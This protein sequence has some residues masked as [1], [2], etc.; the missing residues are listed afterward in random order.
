MPRSTTTFAMGAIVALV[1]G[2]GTAYAAN[3]G[4]LKIGWSNNATQTTTLTNTKGSA[5]YLRSKA[6]QAPLRVNQT[7]KIPA[8]NSDLLDGRD[9]T[10]FAYS[11][12]RI[13]TI[14]RTGQAYDLDGD[15]VP[16]LVTAIAKCP[17]G[18]Q[19]LGGGGLDATGD[20]LLYWNAPS[21]DNQWVVASTTEVLTE[22][23]AANV[24]ASARCWNPRANV[25]DSY[26]VTPAPRTLSPAM[27]KSLSR[28]QR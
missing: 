13:G 24:E 5:L 21:E 14:T 1:L 25:A 4:N 22:E 9:S 6:G 10:G 17:T 20:G 18:S 16:D 26:A 8:L 2:S 27:R 23:N 28:A 7:T 3:G 12:T 15:D 19:L 11:N